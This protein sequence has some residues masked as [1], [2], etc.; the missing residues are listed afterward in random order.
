M[1]WD[2]QDLTPY[3]QRYDLGPWAKPRDTE[4]TGRYSVVAQGLASRELP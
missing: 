3:L 4:I 1:G 2:L